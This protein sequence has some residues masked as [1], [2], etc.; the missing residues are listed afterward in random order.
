MLNNLRTSSTT[1][2]VYVLIVLVVVPL[3][4]VGIYSY[5]RTIQFGQHEATLRLDI[6]T[7]DQQASIRLWLENNQQNTRFLAKLDTVQQLLTAKDNVLEQGA[8]TLEDFQTTHPDILSIRLLGTD[9]SAFYS[10]QSQGS[11]TK[12]TTLTDAMRSNDATLH[13]T[14]LSRDSNGHI[15]V[16]SSAPVYNHEQ[17]LGWLS[18]QTR[19]SAEHLYPSTPNNTDQVTYYLADEKSLIPLSNAQQFPYIDL[20]YNLY[21][22]WLVGRKKDTINNTPASIYPYQDEKEAVAAL[23]NIQIGPQMLALISIQPLQKEY[24]LVKQIE[25]ILTI[26][27]VVTLAIS[28]LAA[29]LILQRISEPLHRLNYRLKR[30]L[31]GQSHGALKLNENSEIGQLSQLFE[32]LLEQKQA[33]EEQV[34]N[35]LRELQERQD[36]ID[37]HSIVS[38]TDMHGNITYVNS[39]FLAISGYLEEDLLGQPHSLTNSDY[40]DQG[41]YDAMRSVVASGHTWHGEVCNQTKGGDYYWLDSTTVPLHNYQHV[42]IG[43]ITISTDITHA[44]AN[45]KSLEQAVSKAEASNEAKNQFL[46]NISHEIRTPMN[47]IIGMLGLMED[48]KLDHMQR[49]YAHTAKESAE[50][51]LAIINDILDFSKIEAQHLELEQID[52]D[53]AALVRSIGA[54]FRTQA[55]SK[56]LELICPANPLPNYHLIGDPGRVRQI[57]NNLIGNAIKFTNQG[58]VSV[59]CQVTELDNGYSQLDIK[60]KDTGIGLTENQIA[61]LFERF[62]QA[63]VSNT[64]KYGGTGLGLAIVKQLVELMQG[65]IDVTS[66]YREGTCMHARIQLKQGKQISHEPNYENLTNQRILVVDDN[67]TNCRLLQHLLNR[68]RIPHHIC[69]SG[70]EALAHLLEAQGDRYS[71]VLVD[72]QMPGM[73]GLQ[74]GQQIRATEGG[75]DTQLIMLSSSDEDGLAYSA[76]QTGFASYLTKPID[77]DSL[78]HAMLTISGEEILNSQHHFDAPQQYENYK[79]RVLAVDDNHINQMVT[80]GMLARFGV[81]VDLAANGIEAIEA[82]NKLPYDIVFMDCHMPEMDGYEATRRIRDGRAKALN[83]NIPIVALTANAMVGDEQI[84][85]SAGMDDYLPKPIQIESVKQKLKHWIKHKRLASKIDSELPTKDHAQAT[86]DNFPPA[87]NKLIKYSEFYE[88][89]G[90]SH[91]TAMMI[92][93]AFMEDAP[94]LEEELQSALDAKD[95]DKLQSF[96]H[97]LKGLA[98]N[99]YCPQLETLA[100]DGEQATKGDSIDAVSYFAEAIPESLHSITLQVQELNRKLS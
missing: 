81:Y 60:V 36:A 18:I 72:Y 45:Q 3:L 68:W 30:R 40:H 12:L 13:G 65:T 14:Q 71:I 10:N 70:D 38:V 80:K 67:Q 95:M 34:S 77:R 94:R 93:N 21:Q 53:I 46:A 35:L 31:E 99:I 4:L 42:N 6:A 84:C 37:E 90:K 83:P 5:Q 2:I 89:I 52:F 56:D 26:A 96:F 17:L 100:K 63:D 32:Q 39:R 86:T 88:R 41:F 98:A 73:N 25:E 49:E 23:S 69:N 61:R 97:K 9:G 91:T 48:T 92:L 33:K 7:A 62:S 66:T 50:S 87:A 76:K 22:Q 11:H 79:A 75:K 82:L 55:N 29:Y 54:S 85:Y 44:K 59:E 20:G 28:A 57:F 16:T 64:R 51:L 27:F 8:S 15:S 78:L 19:L 74:L 24:S 43:F 47:G 58:E 1:I